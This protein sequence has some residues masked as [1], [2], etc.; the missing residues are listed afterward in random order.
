MHARKTAYDEDEEVELRLHHVLDRLGFVSPLLA[1]L[2]LPL[3][4]VIEGHCSQK[5]P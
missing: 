4:S 5:V 1:R 3:K 2:L